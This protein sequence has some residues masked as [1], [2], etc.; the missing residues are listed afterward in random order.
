MNS[1]CL[2]VVL[3]QWLHHVINKCT[4]DRNCYSNVMTCFKCLFGF[5]CSLPDTH[6]TELFVI[7]S[8]N[9]FDIFCVCMVH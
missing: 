3:K 4:A 1:S 9:L 7:M 6:H 8:V 5:T 2:Q